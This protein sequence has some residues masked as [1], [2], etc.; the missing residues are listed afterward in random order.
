VHAETNPET[1]KDLLLFLATAAII[2]PLFTRLHVS[3]ILGYIVGGILLGPFGLGAFAA[4]FP[5]LSVV[6]IT[7][8][9]QISSFAEF[10]VA[11]LLFMIGLE[12]SWD[13]LWRMRRLVFGLGAA[14]VLVSTAILSGF[15]IALHQPATAAVVIGGALAMSSTAII[16]PSLAERKKLTS[17]AGR[18]TFAVLLFQD[19]SVA[20]LLFV[21][22]MLSG[23]AA[24]SASSTAVYL[25]APAVVALV[26]IVV[27]GRFLMRPLFRFVAATG[28]TELFVATSLLVVIGA[29]VAMA[30]GGQSMSLGA[31]AAGLLLGGTEYRRQ[32]AVTVQPFEGLLL[33]L[34]FLAV[35]V[36]LDLS[37]VA[38][39]P[40]LTLGLAI[41]VIV[42]KAITIFPL[43]LA[44]GL[45]RR[46]A[47]DVA[48][49]LAPAGEFALVLTGAAVAGNVVPA[50]TGAIVIIAA[51]LSMLAIPFLIRLSDRKPRTEVTEDPALAQLLPPQV[52]LAQVLV[53][54]YGRVGQ[55]VGEML[56]RHQIPFIAIDRDPTLVAHWRRQHTVIF[57]GDA[58]R[59]ELLRACGI[60]SARALVVT[61]DSTM[62][63]EDVVTAA[64]RERRDLTIVARARDVKQAIRLYQLKVTDAVP[65]TIEA[66][67]QLS[68]AVLMGI[69]VP[70]A[71]VIA[72]IHEKRDE[73]RRQFQAADESGTPTR[74]IRSNGN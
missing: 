22:A 53:V 74:A 3:P 24:S 62:A 55:L 38:A 31:F 17:G 19:L 26:A 73:Y 64:R 68:E 52:E 29:S 37:T 48:L 23:Q 69:G 32:I 44:A 45:P 58:S 54:G 1:Y 67:L 20:P 36:R 57:Y 65:E 40:A 15:Q 25:L 7:D 60:A 8:A 41:V 70:M 13:R 72:S 66:S 28:N 6:T 47:A 12:L 18:A 59:I 2:V 14:Q 10:G 5:W 43:A 49:W 21:V 4:V 35:G 27:L 33:G 30:A 63:I 11:F 16:L 39:L 61:L 51:T 42:L 46:T 34:F 56:D 71:L 50:R 9:S